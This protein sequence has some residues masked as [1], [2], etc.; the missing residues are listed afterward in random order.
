MRCFGG[1]V[2]AFLVVMVPARANNLVTDPGFEDCGGIAGVG[3]PPPGWSASG[4]AACEANPH[5]GSSDADP[6]VDEL[7]TLSQDI[8][9]TVGDS[10]DFSF[11][12]KGFVVTPD[13][14][15]ASFGSDE[16]LDLVDPADFGYTLEDFTVTATAGTSTTIEFEGN[17]NGG[18]WALDDVSVTDLGPAAP[19]PGSVALVAAGLLGLWEFRRRHFSK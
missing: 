13:F 15:T 1:L 18:L 16:V 7:S 11:W 8:S 19:E 2:L 14:F 5:S 17:G 12:L 3:N 10:Y 6:F 9:T 4:A